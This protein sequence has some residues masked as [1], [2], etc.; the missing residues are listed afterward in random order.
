MPERIPQRSFGIGMIMVPVWRPQA[1]NTP[2]QVKPQRRSHLLGL[3]ALVCR[4][5]AGVLAGLLF[6]HSSRYQTMRVPMV[7]HCLAVQAGWR[8]SQRVTVSRGDC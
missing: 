3:V 7:N 5:L 2:L 4:Y 1:H 6:M 8:D